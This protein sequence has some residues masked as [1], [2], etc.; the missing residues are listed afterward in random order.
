MHALPPNREDTIL[1]LS[2]RG[3]ERCLL[4]LNRL[5]GLVLVFVVFCFVFL[6]SN[7][8]VESLDQCLDPIRV[9]GLW[10]IS[11]LFCDADPMKF[12][13]LQE[14]NAKASTFTAFGVI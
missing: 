11:C 13:A 12:R 10:E 6:M 7:R 5:D 9:K 4:L 1:M 3:N 14:R 2:S 8:R